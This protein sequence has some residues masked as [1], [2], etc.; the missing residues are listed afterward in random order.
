MEDDFFNEEKAK[1]LGEQEILIVGIH[2]IDAMKDR[3][4]NL[5]INAYLPSRDKP[6]YTNTRQG[7][8]KL[9][10]N[11][12]RPLEQLA[13]LKNGQFVSLNGP[14]RGTPGGM[15]HIWDDRLV[16]QQKFYPK[17]GD[18]YFSCFSGL[19]GSFRDIQNPSR[20]CLRESLEEF[21]IADDINR[22]LYLPN[23]NSQVILD[24]ESTQVQI[25]GLSKR[26]HAHLL[27]LLNQERNYNYMHFEANTLQGCEDCLVVNEFN[28]RRISQNTGILDLNPRTN[29]FNLLKITHLRGLPETVHFY[30]TEFGNEIALIPF[31]QL[32]EMWQNWG[33]E[34]RVL[35]YAKTGEKRELICKGYFDT[36]VQ[37]AARSLGIID[38]DFKF[39]YKTYG[40][41]S[42]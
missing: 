15:V 25:D 19:S 3:F 8:I 13:A 37:R 10:T 1:Q 6:A 32:R 16:L 29:D 5:T 40:E 42:V 14:F 41:K 31:E 18:K 2:K 38:G 34:T 17:S 35:A 11:P 39:N 12:A 9:E 27:A 23:F 4:G 20:I 24:G 28:G 26:T 7:R 22:I 33:K 36:L 30:E 21:V